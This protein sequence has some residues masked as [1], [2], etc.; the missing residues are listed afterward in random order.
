MADIGKLLQA[1]GIW[2]KNFKHPLSLGAKARVAIVTCM[3]SRLIPEA[4]FGFG[5]GDAEVG[6]RRRSR[7]WSLSSRLQTQPS[8]DCRSY[9]TQ[10]DE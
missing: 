1:A 8:S 7:Q 3:D 5:V 4:I 2:T 6:Q 10:E 9:A